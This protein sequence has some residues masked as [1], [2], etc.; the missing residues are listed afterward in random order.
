MSDQGRA[1]STFEAGLRQP[2]RSQAQPR[3][4]VVLVPDVAATPESQQALA[5]LEHQLTTHGVATLT[6]LPPEQDLLTG[7]RLTSDA[8][9]LFSA[10]A[11]LENATGMAASVCGFGVSALAAVNSA[12]A[13]LAQ[14]AICF[15]LD[16]VLDRTLAGSWTPASS[17]FALPDRTAPG[18]ED[19]VRVAR[20]LLACADGRRS[21]VPLLVIADLEAI[22]HLDTLWCAD[23]SLPHEIIAVAA[24]GDLSGISDT[25]AWT[26]AKVARRVLRWL[27]ELPVRRLA[28]KPRV[29]RLLVAPAGPP[30]DL[31]GKVFISYTHRDGTERAQ[32]I[33]RH[34]DAAGIR[35]FWDTQDLGV[36]D[37][38]GVIEDALRRDA[39][40]GVLVTTEGL[41][42]STF[43]R[44]EELPRLLTA[45]KRQDRALEVDNAFDLD[46]GDLDPEAPDRV[47]GL[48]LGTLTRLTQFDLANAEDMRG[49]LRGWL[50]RKLSPL[51]GAPVAI[52]IQT[53]P[54]T[55]DVDRNKRADLRIRGPLHL[56][57]T[58][59]EM[60]QTNPALSAW[61]LAFPLVSEAL[62]AAAPA[63][64]TITGGAH[65]PLALA[66]GGVLVD[67][68]VKCPVVIDAGKQGVW[69]DPAVPDP[70]DD[71]GPSGDPATISSIEVSPPRQGTDPNAKRVAVFVDFRRGAE[72]LFTEF[73]ERL[74]T[75]YAAALIIR[76]TGPE[77]AH[78]GEGIRLADEITRAIRSFADSTDVN[79][80]EILLCGSLSF[81]MAVLLGMRLNRYSVVAYDLAGVRD[82]HQEHV[83]YQRV[84]ELSSADTQISRVYPDAVP[85][86]QPET[87]Q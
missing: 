61:G 2:I 47:T 44:N 4:G 76:R 50:K 60:A 82:E 37:I 24:D 84:L 58:E 19:A 74:R 59:N 38:T 27:D 30:A 46:N 13:G 86:R 33:K 49:F 64:V 55:Q 80:R 48:P 52:D 32:H 87:I 26:P 43:V 22:P 51:Q 9:D 78:P 57:R 12:M 1:T 56:V 39:A 63:R 25:T 6:L 62:H 83:W 29:D 40:G 18:D 53:Y 10:I 34:L 21:P 8:D 77:L 69:G 66:L 70:L 28:E 36:G 35:N 15:N 11:C 71:H 65:T 81:P 5:E 79:A 75:P 17:S 85:E 31:R 54:L 73:L 45:A 3:A 41:K 72:G 20:D 7:E 67:T 42:D 16:P 14:G 23:A 68:R